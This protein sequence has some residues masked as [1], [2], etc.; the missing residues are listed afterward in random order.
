MRARVSAPRASRRREY[1]EAA[2]RVFDFTLSPEAVDALAH[3]D[4][5][6]S[7]FG[8]HEAFVHDRIL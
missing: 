3:A 2:R 1:V 4:Q 7:L 5:N 8:L 6:V